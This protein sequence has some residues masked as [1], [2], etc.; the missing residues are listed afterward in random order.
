[1]KLSIIIP[2]Y[3]EAEYIGRCLQSI[4][5]N[6]SECLHEI[7]VVDNGS[8]DKTA[9]VAL[10][11]TGVRVIREEKKGL[12]DARQRGLLSATGDIIAYVDA[13]TELPS[14]NW[15]ESIT[16]EF[17]KDKKLVCLSGPYRYYDL[18]IF[19][20]MAVWI[21]WNFLAYPTYLLVGYMVV[22]GNFAT[23]RASLEHIGGFDTTISFYGEDTDIA[24]RLHA[25]GKVKFKLSFIIST[26]GR[27]FKGQGFFKTGFFYVC[28]FLSEV[29]I[30]RPV[31]KKYKDIR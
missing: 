8:S 6:R 29:F 13:D 21:Y 31:T 20:Q 15:F 25:V 1:M 2:A 9:E 27:R 26:S 7:I 18:T 5:K 16:E 22:G 12:T 3:N 23:R 24:R 30:K 19:H 17:S 14:K 28:N 10:Q 11:F 4:I